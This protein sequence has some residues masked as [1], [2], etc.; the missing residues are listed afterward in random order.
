[1]P[2]AMIG[3][4]QFCLTFL[5]ENVCIKLIENSAAVRDAGNC[6]AR[7]S[8]ACKGGGPHNCKHSGQKQSSIHCNLLRCDRT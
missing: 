5:L 1:M 6:I 7:P 8:C 4:L 3:R 2:A